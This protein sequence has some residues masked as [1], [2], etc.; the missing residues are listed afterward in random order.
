MP[1][2]AEALATIKREPA[3]FKYDELLVAGAESWGDF[4]DEGEL[5]RVASTAPLLAAHW[6]RSSWRAKAGNAAASLT[7]TAG[8]HSST[9]CLST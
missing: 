5:G 9:H 4:K 3:A 2:P 7:G 6:C 1:L 8:L